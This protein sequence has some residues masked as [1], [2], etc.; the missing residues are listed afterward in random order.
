MQSAKISMIRAR[1]AR[2]MVTA[3][4]AVTTLAAF[5]VLTTMCWGIYWL[6][7]SSAV[8][9]PRRLLRGRRLAMTAGQ[10]S[11]PRPVRLQAPLSRLTSVLV[12]SQSL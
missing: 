11:K 2:G 3:E 5:A 7:L 4:L 10:W 12:S 9:M 1:D 8:S 6:S